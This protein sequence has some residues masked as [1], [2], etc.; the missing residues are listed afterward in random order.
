MKVEKAKLI[1]DGIK[2]AGVDFAAGVPDAQFTEVYK[3][4]SE[5]PD[6][7]YV[8]AANEGEAAGIVMGAWF[9]GKKPALI[10]ATSG[11]LV[12]MF[13]LARMQLLHEVPIL[14]LIPYRG[15]IGDPLWMGMYR[16]TT[17]AALR[18]LDIPYRI[19]NESADIVRVIREC[20]EC[21]RSWLKSVAVLFS[22]EALW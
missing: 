9:G 7:R 2:A 4:V 15:D 21:A 13:S 17:E 10:I 5:N 6:I 22:E 1:I 14:I 20:N 16:K 19:V 18:T 8:G 3:M 11:L 12:A